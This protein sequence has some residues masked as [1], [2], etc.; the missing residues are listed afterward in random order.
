MK[1]NRFWIKTT[2]RITIDREL[3][4]VPILAGSNLSKSDAEN[5]A[6]EIVQRIQKRIDTN[7]RT[8]EYESTIKEWVSEMLDEDNVV[9]VNR[10]GALVLN[11]TQYTILDLDDYPF[12][13][14]DIFG[15]TRGRD[16]KSLI[17][18]RFKKKIA[19]LPFLGSD[20]R[21][22]ET[23][24]GL[25]VFCK[26][27]IPP[28]TPGFLRWMSRFKVDSLYAYLCIKQ[29]CYRA[30]LTPKPYR[31]H[32]DK[33]RIK[34]PLDCETEKYRSWNAGYE[35]KSKSFRVAKLLEAIGS[36]FSSDR[37]V[38]YHDRICNCSAE[39]PLA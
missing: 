32:Q 1:T 20:L 29:D 13:F 5:V 31:I 30:R 12:E 7:Q 8:Q 15:R 27:Y 18:E 35:R 38:A 19:K 11:T 23:S 3:K 2:R 14:L 10:Y 36:D 21:I 6:D 26:T 28:Q 39:N 33:I 22:Y 4:E 24:K 25:R 16:K 37:V 9:T 34:S 17:L